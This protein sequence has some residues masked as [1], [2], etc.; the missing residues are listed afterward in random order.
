MSQAALVA[1]ICLIGFVAGLNLVLTLAV[2]RKVNARTSA[3]SQIM[4]R[5]RRPPDFRAPLLDG[6]TTSLRDF[7]DRPTVFVFA[8][9]TCRPCVDA[10]P[11]YARLAKLAPAAGA[12]FVIVSDGERDA[13]RK[14]LDEYGVACRTILAPRSGHPLM[15]E[16][17][18]TGTPSFVHIEKGVVRS[19]G[20]TSPNVLVWQKIL[21]WL[22]PVGASPQPATA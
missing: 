12:E 17:N 10:M 20:P 2:I 11:S 16:W 1:T 19:S 22:D 21:Q 13:T 15:N 9:P 8:S 5:G 4:E 7:A 18:I 6:S 14:L 3:S